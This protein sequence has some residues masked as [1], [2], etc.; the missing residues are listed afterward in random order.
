MAKER[1]DLAKALVRASEKP[2][3]P[4]KTATANPDGKDDDN[5][6]GAV[7]EGTTKA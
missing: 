2:T 6:D 1:V 5:K 4:R 3:K 7:A